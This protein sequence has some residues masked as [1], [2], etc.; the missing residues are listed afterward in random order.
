[1]LL[2]RMFASGLPFWVDVLSVTVHANSGSCADPPDQPLSHWNFEGWSFKANYV[3]H[4]PSSRYALGLRMKQLHHAVAEHQLHT[5]HELGMNT[6]RTP[7]FPTISSPAQGSTV[8]RLPRSTAK[9][10]AATYRHSLALFSPRRVHKR[11]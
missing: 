8:E 9:L 4:S 3:L 7:V 6:F 1:M 10:F 5:I 11:P 2:G